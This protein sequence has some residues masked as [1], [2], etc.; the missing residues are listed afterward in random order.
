MT[1]SAALGLIDL[2][3]END[4]QKNYNTGG[5]S[6]RNHCSQFIADGAQPLG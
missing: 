2:D 3:G 1:S 6:L 5:S 4:A